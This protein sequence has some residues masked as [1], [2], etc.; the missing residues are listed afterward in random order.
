MGRLSTRTDEQIDAFVKVIERNGPMN[1]ALLAAGYTP[2]QAKKGKAKL[3]AVLVR[4]LI[5]HGGRRYMEMGQALSAQEQELIVRGRLLANAIS[6]KDQA[7]KSLELMGK[8][9]R[10]NMFTPDSQVG[11]IVLGDATKVSADLLPGAALGSVSNPDLLPPV[12]QSCTHHRED[13]K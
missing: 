3:P 5:E 9:R 7:V 12:V 11:I 13:D 4:A 2:A 10:V 8:D 1:E 6:G